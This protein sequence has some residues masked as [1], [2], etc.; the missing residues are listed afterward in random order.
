M[1]YFVELVDQRLIT[2]ITPARRAWLR[3]PRTL[4]LGFIGLHLLFLFAL[5]PTIL[6][7][8]VLGDLP[9]YRVWAEQALVNNVW[10][11]IN[12]EWVYPIGAIVPVVLADTAG[13]LLYQLLWFV[14]TAMLNALAIGILTDWGRNRAGYKAAW[15]WLAFSL[16]ISPVGLLR[17]E[18]LSAP[19]VIMGLVLLAR[20]PVIASALLTIAT[21]IK[22]WPA[23]V[24][25]A[26]VAASRRRIPVVV[27]GAAISAG[28]AVA[29]WAAG[30]LRFLTGFVTMQS[31]RA[32]QLEAPVTTPWVWLAA[33]G[34]QGTTIYQNHAI[35][36]REVA[37]PG[38]TFV[39]GI[40]TPLM[41]LIMAAIFVLLLLALRR[42][43]DNAQLVLMGALALVSTFVVLNKVGS[44]QYMLWIAPVVA[45][46][47]AHDWA[48]WRVP[49]YLIMVIGGLTTLIFPIFYLPLVH[50]DA[51]AILL[52]TLRNG[53]LVVLLGWSVMTLW[54]TARACSPASVSVRQ[55]SRTR[56]LAAN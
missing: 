46:G 33:M 38:T 22:V 7:G 11:G 13:P 17:L 30:G 35:A 41:F 53:L 15:F 48:R 40:M 39:A 2:L 45:V 56:G 14:M 3:S 32:L 31:D 23:A 1:S 18:G 52:L 49:A 34:H 9:L 51:G 28:I 36:T 4:L 27:T 24:M 44:P 10:Q 20:R 6:T 29:V 21:W 5:L 50:G 12:V 25:L 8:R 37:G 16:V 19:L 43:R 26:V 47:V 42:S 54:R 55:R